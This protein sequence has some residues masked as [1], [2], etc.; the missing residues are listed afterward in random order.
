M[1]DAALIEAVL[2]DWRAA[3]ISEKLRAM[4]GF[5]ETLTLRPGDLSAAEIRAMRRAG[6][7][8][9]AIEEAIVICAAFSIAD[10]LADTFDYAP[11]D[12]EGARRGGEYLL[13]RGY[14]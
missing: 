11:P 10:R 1:N 3:P 7:S 4:L 6:V 2:T 13:Q 12:A 14:R 9:A 5:L 8:D